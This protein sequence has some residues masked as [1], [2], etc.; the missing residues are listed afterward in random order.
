MPA[1]KDPSRALAGVYILVVEDDE[2]SRSILTAV[3][4]YYGAHVVATSSADAALARLKVLRPDVVVT[5]IAMPSHDGVWL[6]RELRKLPG[7]ENIAVVAV[8]AVA[9]PHDLRGAG[10]HT[11][12]T[13]PV[14]P[15]AL[16]DV[17]RRVMDLDG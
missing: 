2:D 13:K 7:T 9:E 10:F 15:Q 14:D 3:L 1:A 11:A 17:I 12:L 8:T 16:C 6:L 5:D 4:R